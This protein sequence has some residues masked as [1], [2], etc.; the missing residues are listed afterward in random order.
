[1]SFLAKLDARDPPKRSVSALV[2]QRILPV[3]AP[4]PASRIALTPLVSAVFSVIP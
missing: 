2:P 4:V 3:T 1:M